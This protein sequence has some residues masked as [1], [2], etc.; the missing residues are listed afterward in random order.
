MEV[1]VARLVCGKDG[2]PLK[3]V[4]GLLGKSAKTLNTHVERIYAKMDVC[5]RVALLWA[6][7]QKGYLRCPCGKNDPHSTNAPLADQAAE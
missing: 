1:K 5:G 6:L 2:A 3:Q 4:A 7:V